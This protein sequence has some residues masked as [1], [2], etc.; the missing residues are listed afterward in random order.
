M[1]PEILDPK[2]TLE[3]GH[4]HDMARSALPWTL[5]AIA[6]GLF[7]IFSVDGGSSSRDAKNALL[8]GIVIAGALLFLGVL[9]YRRA[10]PSVPSLVISEQGILFRL[11]SEKVIPWDEVRDVRR[12]KV[13]AG[14]DFL[15][16]K[17]VRIAL[18][19]A[20]YERYTEGR[21][22][23]SVTGESGSRDSAIFLAYYLN[24]PHE[25]LYVAV[26][27]RWLAF[28]HRAV[29]AAAEAIDALADSA[30]THHTRPLAGSGA[31]VTPR[32]NSVMQ[33]ASSF[34]GLAA[35]GGLVRGASFGQIAGSVTAL[36]I[37][38]AL[39]SNILG[40]WATEA[41]VKGRAEAAKWKAW[42]EQQDREQ[43]AFD[44]EQKK[45]REKFD[46]MFRCMNETFD[47]G[48][49]ATRSAECEKDRN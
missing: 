5:G 15:S 35:L 25:E 2:R 7:M 9:V 31:G 3:Y 28:S 26:R 36:A 41:Q 12:D 6:L 32:R 39:L 20:F 16:T 43:A 37:I 42:Q 17:V 23:E 33:R 8:G 11:V 21:W 49:G 46:L 44:A 47:R 34:E 1:R 48:P 45:T 38:A 22:H 18:S 14:R 10:Q 13:R 19:P 27:K 30:R 4:S 29:G 24:V 40:L